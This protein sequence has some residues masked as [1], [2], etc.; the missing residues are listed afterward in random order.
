ML[1]F[2]E[3]LNDNNSHKNIILEKSAIVDYYLSHPDKMKSVPITIAKSTENIDLH[4]TIN[5]EFNKSASGNKMLSDIE[6]LRREF[7]KITDDL[8]QDMQ[9][10]DPR[11]GRYASFNYVSDFIEMVEL[12]NKEPKIY[13]PTFDKYKSKILKY[14]NLQHIYKNYADLYLNKIAL[15]FG[16]KKREL[17]DILKAITKYRD[18]SGQKIGKELASALNAVTVTNA[19]GKIYRGWF[20]GGEIVSKIKNIENLKPGDT[21]SFSFGK[22]TSWSTMKNTAYSFTTAQNM[23]KDVQNG[24]MM[25]ISYKPKKE[26]VVADLRSPML[27]SVTSYYNQQEIILENGKKIFTVEWINKGDDINKTSNK[28][29]GSTGG[30]GSLSSKDIINRIVLSS[31]PNLAIKKYIDE[32]KLAE[33]ISSLPTNEVLKKYSHLVT[34]KLDPYFKSE[35]YRLA[36][37]FT[38]LSRESNIIIEKKGIDFFSTDIKIY[39]DSYY[40]LK[41]DIKITNY[42]KLFTKPNIILSN[43]KVFNMKGEEIEDID[44]VLSKY[45]EDID[46]LFNIRVEV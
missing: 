35:P 10:L 29:S 45:I 39:T 27:S 3:F 6:E 20:V 11:N 44:D 17:E 25:V 31:G 41:A 30:A 24:Y 9:A 38:Q 8:K 18:M 5:F 15:Q 22:P 36:L 40:K 12:K 33:L 43:I 37:L 14:I 21:F 26:E 4:N 2:R 42:E 19:P 23:V 16:V 34:I 7:V 1:S 13:T 32:L 28:I 46:N